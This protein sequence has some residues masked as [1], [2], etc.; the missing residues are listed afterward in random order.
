MYGFTL[1]CMDGDNVDV[2]PRILL[3]N[4]PRAYRQAIAGAIQE[5]RPNVEVAEVEPGALEGALSLGA[6]DLVVCS[7]A[8]TTV[9][10]TAPAWVELYTD[11]G[12]SSSIGIGGEV[13]T[14]EN[15]ELTDLLLVVDRAVSVPH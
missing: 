5:L 13:S 7:L 12:S 14:A 1:R 9:R 10:E 3:A 11:H 2:K 6:P 8:T 15:I 4:T